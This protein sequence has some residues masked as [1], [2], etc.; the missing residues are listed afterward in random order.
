MLH[1]TERTIRHHLDLR[2]GF[3]VWKSTRRAYIFP[4]K[5]KRRLL[6]GPKAWQLWKACTS[7]T[8]CSFFLQQT[9]P[10]ND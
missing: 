6:S 10:Y 4:R 5:S 8:Y 7:S 3:I 9:Y 1:R 2:D